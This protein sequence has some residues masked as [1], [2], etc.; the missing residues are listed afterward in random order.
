MGKEDDASG[1]VE[2]GEGIHVRRF[3]GSQMRRENNLILTSQKINESDTRTFSNGY[4]NI[5]GDSFIVFGRLKSESEMDRSLTIVQILF[6]SMQMATDVLRRRTNDLEKVFNV[7]GRGDG[8][9]KSREVLFVLFPLFSSPLPSPHGMLIIVIIVLLHIHLTSS[10]SHLK[11]ECLIDVLLLEGK[12]Q[13]VELLRRV[14]SIVD[15]RENGEGGLDGE[16]LGGFEIN[17]RLLSLVIDHTRDTIL[18]DR[19]GETRIESYI[20]MTDET[21]VISRQLTR[22]SCHLDEHR[23]SAWEGGL[24]ELANLRGHER[25]QPT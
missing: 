3:F 14:A 13:R 21:P 16:S 15:L 6:E 4:I 8:R 10:I 9:E 25:A 22:R 12:E 5:C 18:I 24:D 20:F 1:R 23:L 17:G 2:R 7:F 19:D 11:S